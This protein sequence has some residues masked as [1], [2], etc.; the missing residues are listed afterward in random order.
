[1]ERSTTIGTRWLIQFSLDRQRSHCIECG[2]VVLPVDR[3]LHR[4]SQPR[5]CLIR[6][7]ILMRFWPAKNFGNKRPVLHREDRL[8]AKQ[9]IAL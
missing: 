1:M 6:L 2:R 7:L 9:D 3:N 8:L 4:D 5:G